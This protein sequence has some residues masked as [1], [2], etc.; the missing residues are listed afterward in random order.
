VAERAHSVATGFLGCVRLGSGSN[1]GCRGSLAGADPKPGAGLLRQDR[2]LVVGVEPVT[3][4]GNGGSEGDG[5]WGRRW[6]PSHRRQLSS[7]RP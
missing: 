3:N 5:H 4:S 2:L 6:G 1:G 7:F